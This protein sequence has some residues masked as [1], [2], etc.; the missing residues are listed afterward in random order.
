MARWRAIGITEIVRML[1]SRSA[2]LISSTRQS[3]AMAMNILRMVAACWASLRVELQPVEFGD[4]V[5]DGGDLLAEL[6]TQ[7]LVGDAGVLDGVVQQR[8]GDR[9]LVEAEVGRD[10]GDG[11][12]VGDVGLAGSSQLAL[13]GVDRQPDPRDGSARRRRPRGAREIA[14]SAARSSRS[15]RDRPTSAK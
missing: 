9:G 3:W 8:R 14:R 5:D 6:V 2:S 12:R 11:D 4:P 10:V 15:A 7:P 13:V 1:C